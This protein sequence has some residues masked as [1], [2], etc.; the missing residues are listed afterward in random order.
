MVFS[1]NCSTLLN[2]VAHQPQSRRS[3]KIGT[4]SKKRTNCVL[5]AT[6]QAILTPLLMVLIS[7]TLAAAVVFA[8]L[9]IL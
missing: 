3:I 6:G 9:W 1:A 7:G 5:S 8:L 2:S 4:G